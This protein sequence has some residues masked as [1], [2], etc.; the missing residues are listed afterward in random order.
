[1]DTLKKEIS[2][3]LCGILLGVLISTGGFAWFL[4]TSN[5]TSVSQNRQVVLKLGHSLDTSHPV[6]KAMEFM[7][8]RLEEL[9]GDQVT[10]D[11]YPSSVLGSEVECLEQLQNGS[12][13][14]T[15]TSAASMRELY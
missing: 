7:K 2:F 14:M 4:R 8:K 12:L 1:M 13:A 6:H 15:K 11:I 10:M 5:N 9:S 3:L